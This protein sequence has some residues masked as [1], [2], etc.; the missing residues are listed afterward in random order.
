MIIAENHRHRVHAETKRL[1]GDATPGSQAFLGHYQSALSNIVN[2]L[3]EKEVEEAKET[4]K[5]WNSRGP[6]AE[7]QKRCVCPVKT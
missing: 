6:P 3:S 4:A 7:V 2:S 1:A 5:E